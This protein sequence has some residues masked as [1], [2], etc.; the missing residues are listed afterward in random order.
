MK[1][2]LVD[3]D[4]TLADTSAVNYLAYKDA[5]EE[6][7]YTIDERY[8]VC[9]C[10]GKHYLD[11]LPQLV[12][13][14]K[15]LIEII[16]KK[17]KIAYKDHINCARVNYHLVEILNALKAMAKIVIVTTASK[18]NVEE[19][20]EEFHLVELFD[21]IITGDDVKNKKPNPEGFLKAMLQYGCTAEE[22]IIFEDSAEGLE[23]ARA[24]KV[25]CYKVIGYR[26]EI[27][28]M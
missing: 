15:E 8:Y 2:V 24:A 16:H 27:D 5:I 20:L 26:G 4:G 28:G 3:F 25:E 14:N 18:K 17:K 9:K 1:L 11:F 10:N 22:T 21:G 13:D 23:A 7:G 6:Y 19:L 12:G